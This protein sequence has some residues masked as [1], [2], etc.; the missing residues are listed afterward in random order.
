M[1]KNI[2][3]SNHFY[4]KC[5]QKIDPDLANQD[6]LLKK[7]K[8][9]F[10]QSWLLL[11]FFFIHVKLL[12]CLLSQRSFRNWQGQ[13]SWL[14]MTW[15]QIWIFLYQYNT[16]NSHAITRKGFNLPNLKGE[17]GTGYFISLWCFMLAGRWALSS[18]DNII[19]ATS[20]SSTNLIWCQSL[21]ITRDYRT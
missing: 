11:F 12:A 9:K 7:V 14:T 17:G 16:Q 21:H 1:K 8:K 15:G 20:F 13:T 10:D 18:H 6:E 19:V 2:F 5:F 4:L 3:Q